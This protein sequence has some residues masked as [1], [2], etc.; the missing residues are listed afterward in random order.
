MIES[1]QSYSKESRVQ[2]F[3][4]TLYMKIISRKKITTSYA[5]WSLWCTKICLISPNVSKRRVERTVLV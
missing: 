2:F 1:R 4:P 3:W 5:V